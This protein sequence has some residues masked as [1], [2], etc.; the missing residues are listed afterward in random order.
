M[1]MTNLSTPFSKAAQFRCPQCN[2]TARLTMIE[3]H[4]SEPQKEWHVF[5]CE[6]C[7]TARTYL[8]SR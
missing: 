5:R 7:S 8:T 2:G 3:P 1:P 4:V 6:T